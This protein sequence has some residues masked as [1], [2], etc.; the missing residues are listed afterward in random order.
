MFH[1]MGF[2]VPFSFDFLH[3]AVKFEKLNCLQK[4]RLP[5]A[6]GSVH[7]T[8]PLV[9]KST[10]VIDSPIASLAGLPDGLFSKQKSQFG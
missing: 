8:A 4:D 5:E 9:L 6:I 3:I 7:R 2:D 1:D 10:F